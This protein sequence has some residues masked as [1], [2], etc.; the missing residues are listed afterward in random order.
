MMSLKVDLIDTLTNEYRS[1]VRNSETLMGLIGTEIAKM[2]TADII[3]GDLT[4][5]NM[6]LRRDHTPSTSSST[7]HT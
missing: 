1:Q 6:M 7:T 2:H 3:H 4:T 5:S